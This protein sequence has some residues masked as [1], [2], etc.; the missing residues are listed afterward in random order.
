MRRPFFIIGLMRSGTTLLYRYLRD[1]PKIALTNEAHVADFLAQCCRHAAVPFRETATAE[2]LSAVDLIGVIHEREVSAFARIFRSHA[3]AALEEFYRERFGGKDFSHWG[4]K[5][6]GAF[7]AMELQDVYPAVRFVA[8]VRD[9]RDVWCSIRDYRRRAEV[10]RSWMALTADQLGQVW[11]NTYRNFSAYLRHC[12]LLTYED[13]LRDPRSVLVEVYKFLG[14]EFL[15]P[16]NVAFDVEHATS[17][18]P[19]GSIGR[20]RTTLSRDEREA[21][22]AHAGVLMDELGY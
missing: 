5:L 7:T 13:L 21:I 19:R 16:P 9:P 11:V 17:A 18:S 6:P 10:P 12:H 22:E 15:V 1:H 3:K 20:W 8:I 14:L 2:Y 4:D